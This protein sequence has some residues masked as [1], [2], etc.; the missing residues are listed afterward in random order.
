[1]AGEATQHCGGR[2][3]LTRDVENEQDGQV[4]RAGEFGGGAG[5]LGARAVEQAHG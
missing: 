4:K 5:S 2:L 1:M 3:G